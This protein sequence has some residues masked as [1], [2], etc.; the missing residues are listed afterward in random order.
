MQTPLGNN[1]RGMKQ[2]KMGYTCIKD[3]HTSVERAT[4]WVVISK[5]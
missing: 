5:S 4:L 1:D 3:S 2:M